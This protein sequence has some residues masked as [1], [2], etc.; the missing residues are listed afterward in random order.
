ME[1]RRAASSLKAFV[2]FVIA[3]HKVMDMA[4]A[5]RFDKDG[6][7]GV[8]VIENEDITHVAVGGNR[9]RTWEVRANE[10]LKVL[11]SKGGSADF[12]LAVAMVSWWG[13]DSVFDRARSLT[14]CG[15]DVTLCGA[16]FLASV[17]HFSHDSWHQLGEVFANQV[18]GEVWPGSEE[19]SVDGFVECQDGWITGGGM[20]QDGEFR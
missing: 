13:E 16:D 8:V 3:F 9:K 17:F 19:T 11:P 20:E 1:D 4:A 14:L 2:A 15:V 7:V 10:T 12:M 6:V 18:T 5:D